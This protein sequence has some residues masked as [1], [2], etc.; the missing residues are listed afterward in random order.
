MVPVRLALTAVLE[1]REQEALEQHRQGAGMELD[2]LSLLE[3][4]V[5]MRPMVPEGGAVASVLVQNDKM[6]SGSVDSLIMSVVPVV[7]VVLV[8]VAVKVVLADKVEVL[9]LRFS[10]P[11]PI[12]VQHSPSL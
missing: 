2:G 8:V 7:A 6:V 3:Q 10:I 4:M 1:H 5:Q 9:P 12:R 11:V